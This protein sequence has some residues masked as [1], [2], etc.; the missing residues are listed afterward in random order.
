MWLLLI[1][2][3]ILILI[4]FPIVL[5]IGAST[6]ISFLISHLPLYMI[7]QKMFDGINSYVLLAVPLF[8]LAGNFMDQGGLSKRIVRLSE[9]IVGHFRGGL[10]MTAILASMFFAGVSG[11]A[12]ADTAAIGS[13]LIP[14]MKKNGYPKDLSAS[15]I[16]AGGSIGVI[17]PPSIPMIIFG[18]ISDVSIGKLFIAG[19]L[20]GILIGLSLIIVT[21]FTAK[22]LNI[23]PT[24]EKFDFKEFKSA[25]KDSIWAL[26]APIIII[27]GILG[28][29][30]TA[31]ESAAVAVVYSFLVGK[32]IYKELTWE[33]FPKATLS[34]IVTSAVILIIISVASVFAWF[35]SIKNIQMQLTHFF[36][37]ITHDK[38]LLVILINIFLLIMGTFVETAASLILFVPVVAPILNSIGIDP[39]TSG[40]MIV[41]NLA[42]GM[43]TPPLGICLIVSGSIADSKIIEVSKAIMPFLIAMIID[44]FI[45]TFFSPLTTYLPKFV[46]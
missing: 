18:F 26:G 20:P 37:T 39:L 8:M 15:I 7:P 23:N 38:I 9:A 4:S 17:I 28:G 11:S 42:I 30:F 41:T 13:I 5:A 34:S 31:T 24:K 32:F 45:I 14:S 10:A 43:L 16:A 19:I 35:L 25:L 21:L 3:I 27:G 36:L 12:A 2:L 46:G 29:V 6:T 44:L 40:V 33:N 22:K 1:V